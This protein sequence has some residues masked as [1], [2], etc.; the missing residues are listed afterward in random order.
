MRSRRSGCSKSRWVKVSSLQKP[1]PPHRKAYLNYKGPVSGGRGT[2]TR[3]DRGTCRPL[4]QSETVHAWRLM[5]TR[6]NA[7]ITLSSDGSTWSC[8]FERHTDKRI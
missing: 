5:G 1:L 8:K 4:H 6:I 3:W 2:V 7:T